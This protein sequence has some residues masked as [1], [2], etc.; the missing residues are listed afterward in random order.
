MSDTVGKSEFRDFSNKV[1]NEEL[2]L[3]DTLVQSYKTNF[4]ILKIL[5]TVKYTCNS[6]FTVHLNIFS[7][8]QS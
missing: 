5:K 4:N 2:S 1:N 3:K 7:R 8:S 6:L